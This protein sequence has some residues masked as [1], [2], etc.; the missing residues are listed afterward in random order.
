MIQLGN[1]L[2]GWVLGALAVLGTVAGVYLRGRAAGKQSE[3][4]KETQRDL[5][6]ER[7]KAQTIQEANDAQTEV[8]R[9]PADAVHQ[10][11]RDKW[12]RDT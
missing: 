8:S 11:L 4:A 9:L 2:Y 6:T 7:E 12:Q 3:Q 5:A 10:R 1:K